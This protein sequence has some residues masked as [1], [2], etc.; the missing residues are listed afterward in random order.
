MPGAS[1]LQSLRRQIASLESAGRPDHGV[2]PFGDDR[3]DGHLAG[4]GLAR[5]VWHTLTSD[6]LEME[7]GAAADVWRWQKSSYCGTISTSEN[8]AF[9]RYNNPRMFDLKSGEHTVLSTAIRPGC[10]INIIPAGGLVLV[11][12]SSAGCTCGHPIQ[13]TMAFLPR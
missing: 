9:S 3:I 1:R 7:T 11:P 2:T 4:G 10:W 13:T 6:G 8:C 5:G 12:E